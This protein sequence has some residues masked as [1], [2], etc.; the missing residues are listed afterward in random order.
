[1][2]IYRIEDFK[3][4][5]PYRSECLSTMDRLLQD[6]LDNHTLDLYHPA[7]QYDIGRKPRQNEICGFISVQQALEWFPIELQRKLH[8]YGFSLRQVP[9]DIITAVGE[10]QVLAIKRIIWN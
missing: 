5:G 3:G 10:F 1:M 2:V 7:P 4:R 9:V 8:I 6:E